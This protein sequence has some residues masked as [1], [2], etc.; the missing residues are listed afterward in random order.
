MKPNSKIL[1]VDDDR[2]MSKTICDILMVKGYDVLEANSGGEAL[3]M[4]KSAVP[5]C[6]IMDIRM[7]VIDGIQ[8]LKMLKEMAP[9]LPVIM[10]SAYATEEQ[11]CMAKRFG[12][13]GVLDKPIDIQALLSFLS[14]LRK[15]KSILIVDDDPEF[16]KTLRDIL[17]A[18][19]FK[20]ETEGNPEN[21]ISCMEREYKL[22][23]L[24]DLKLGDK[25]GTEV[26][27][28]IRDRYPTKPVILVTGYGKEMTGSVDKGFQIGAYACMY[29]PFEI[30]TL[31]EYIE[32]ID[33]K[34]LQALLGEKIDI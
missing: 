33:H 24:L 6:V 16:T 3:E 14:V 1:V 10:M 26:L 20:V 2:R 30:E 23:V 34:K 32:E 28:A 9:D 4:V 15:E 19:G 17:Q 7:E 5:D 11:L 29:K 22:V 25:D 8:T 31:I 27:K 21:V 18:R 12:A 13:Y